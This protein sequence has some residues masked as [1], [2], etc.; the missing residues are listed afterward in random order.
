MSDLSAFGVTPE[1]KEHAAI[2]SGKKELGKV[3]G[4]VG[5]A[6]A[7][8]DGQRLFLGRGSGGMGAAP[9]VKSDQGP[10]VNRGSI[11]AFKVRKRSVK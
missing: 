10:G 1:R 9:R 4:A 11:T 8:I 2:K 6:N 5:D 3:P 7:R